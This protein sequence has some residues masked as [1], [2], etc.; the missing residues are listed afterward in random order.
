[1][2]KKFLISLAVIVLVL[3]LGVIAY[4]QRGVLFKG[5]VVALPDLTSELKAEKTQT[6]TIVTCTVKNIGEPIRADQSFVTEIKQGEK[7]LQSR[8]WNNSKKASFRKNQAVSYKVY[9]PANATGQISCTA[10][11]KNKVSESDDDRNTSS[12]SLSEGAATIDV[13]PGTR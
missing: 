10:D 2:N 9:L 1:M 3:A 7:T 6:S 11:A 13:S 5:A 4:T 8:I 12:A